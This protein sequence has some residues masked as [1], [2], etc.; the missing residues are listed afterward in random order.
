MQISEAG[1]FFTCTLSVLITLISFGVN[2]FSFKSTT[3]TGSTIRRKK[4]IAISADFCLEV[5]AFFILN[6]C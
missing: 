1:Y 5:I 4:I 6:L 3:V 2:N